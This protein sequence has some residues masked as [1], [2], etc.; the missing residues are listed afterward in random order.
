[1]GKLLKI[2][3]WTIGLVLL[4][5]VAAVLILPQIVDPND[6]KEE[7]ISS[8]KAQTGRDLTI[9]GRIGLS[10][11][12]WLG[13]ETGA[14]A[15]G[16]AKGFGEKAFAAIER[17]GVRVKLMPLLS[18]KL[19]VD[20][21]ELNGLE[22]NLMR[23]KDGTSNWDDLAGGGRQTEGK[24]D[25]EAAKQGQRAT[26]SGLAALTIGGIDIS[27]AKI[28]WDDRSS[29]Q[30]VSLDQ[31]RLSSGPVIAGEPVD[32][33]L[34]MLLENRDPAVKAK[35]DLSGVVVL[36]E[37]AGVVD[38]NGLKITLDATGDALPGGAVKAVLEAAVSAAL[39][40]SQ[41]DISGLSLT[42]GGLKLSGD[43]KG[44]D[45]AKRPAFSGTL[46]LAEFNLRQWMAD[47]ALKLPSLADAKALTRLAAR[48]KLNA[49]DGA[50]RLND[51]AVRL[52]DSQLSGNITLRGSAIGFNLNLDTIDVD[53]YLPAGGDKARK[54]DKADKADK[55]APAQSSAPVASAGRGRGTTEEETLL[56]IETLRG[57][58]LDGT[59]SI[60]RLTINNLLAEQIK[61]VLKAREGQLN[62]GQQVRKFYQGEYSGETSLD[63]RSKTP[64]A[65]IN[66][67]AAGIQIGPLLQDLSGQERL[68][69]RG[70]FSANLDMR[71]NSV[72]AFKRTLG[73]KLD[74]NFEDGAVKGFN[75]AQVIR[76]AKARLSGKPVPKNSQ[77]EQTDFSE[78][79][80]S[81]RITRGVLSNR[82]LLAKSPFLRVNGAGEINLV[83]ESLDYT[84]EGVVVNTAKGQGGEGLD[85]LQ[86]VVIPVQLTGPL[87]SPKYTINWEKVLL[88]SQKG[89]IKEKIQEKL[90]EKLKGGKLPGGLQ[91]KL[92]GLFN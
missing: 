76:E 65:R 52:D 12:P 28:F 68:T 53:R 44:R 75:A 51:L 90:E 82:D 55:D 27:D 36:K 61:L 10:V 67:A 72:N 73:G 81:G 35:L 47:H 37:T 8:V 80:G 20:R 59:I 84:I 3:G 63:V 78:L 6:Y 25:A 58:D 21:I 26:E 42:A 64:R 71:G 56:P 2:L 86:G 5:L 30:S 40:G 31:F 43:L 1:M 57:L 24:A 17:A 14:V 74:F 7:I 41:L 92:K 85:E 38:V 79:S 19:E 46:D 88:E 66:T 22:L 23:L 77:P 4:L 45:L 70:R 18:R 83:K 11:F 69:G 60:G 32:L 62:L 16:N 29:G 34:G 33:Q 91:D 54:D 48:V 9:D 15:L 13:V 49:E 89:K 87:A 39:N 50:T